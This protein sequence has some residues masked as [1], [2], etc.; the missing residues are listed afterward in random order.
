MSLPMRKTYPSML[1]LNVRQLQRLALILAITLLSGCGGGGD[2]APVH[3]KSSSAGENVASTPDPAL[4]SAPDTAASA[5]ASVLSTPLGTPDPAEPTP[6]PT[7]APDSSTTTV[8]A[9]N[10]NDRQAVLDLYH[11]V[12]VGA[13]AVIPQWTG[14]TSG[15]NAGDTSM[16]WKAAVVRT[17]N[18]YRV[19]AGLPGNVTLNMTTSALAQQAAL[20]MEVNWQLSHS[21]PTSWLC[22]SV[23]GATAASQSNIALGVIGP[24]AMR[25]YMSDRNVSSLGHR[26]GILYS[27]LGEVGTGDSKYA[28][29]LWIVGL[30]ASIPASVNLLGVAWP[31]RGYVPWT[32]KVA[33]PY[34]EWSFSLPG[35]DFS[36]SVVKMTNDQ[37]Q[38]LALSSVSQREGYGDNTIGWKLA[39]EDTLW[40]RSPSDTLLRVQVNNVIVNGSAK[41]FAYDVI[42]FVP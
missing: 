22:Y 10:T 4:A 18:S 23:G 39:A 3:S 35:A 36:G 19:L 20:M 29:A 28:N 25:F 26:R 41:N 40:S 34:D 38:D 33:N 32:Y 16:E 42:F 8:P 7:P 1:H 11:N 12:I 5:P 2:V 17:V 21:P 13:F 6:P 31:P 14:T 27:K 15:C 30:E 9:L 24:E 37:G